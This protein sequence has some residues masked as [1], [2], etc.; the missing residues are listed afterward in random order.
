MC[1]AMRRFTHHVGTMQATGTCVKSKHYFLRAFKH[2][3]DE[4]VQYDEHVI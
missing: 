2:T 3:T 4:T 1:A